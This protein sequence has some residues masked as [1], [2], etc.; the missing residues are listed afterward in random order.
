MAW[1]AFILRLICGKVGNIK[2]FLISYILSRKKLNKTRQK[3]VGIANV[4]ACLKQVLNEISF[5]FHFVFC[6]ISD[7]RWMMSDNSDQSL[8]NGGDSSSESEAGDCE[9]NRFKYCKLVTCDSG[10]KFTKLLRQIC[11]IFLNFKVS[12]RSSYS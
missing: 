3:N 9:N 12:L 5:L 4:N 8:V 1:K 10:W 7:S 11:K 2:F 6:F